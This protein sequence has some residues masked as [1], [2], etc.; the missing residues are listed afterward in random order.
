MVFINWRCCPKSV[1]D[2]PGKGKSNAELGTPR[3]VT[4]RRRIWGLRMD[5][6]LSVRQQQEA[7]VVENPKPEPTPSLGDALTGALQACN[8]ISL[9]SSVMMKPD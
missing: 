5:H 3:E 2:G 6:K 4:L 9:F 7:L 8:L 1:G